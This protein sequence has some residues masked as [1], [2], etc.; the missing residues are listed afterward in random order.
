M[1]DSTLFIKLIQ[2]MCVVATIA[3]VLT[4]ID[5]FKRIFQDNLSSKD[6]CFLI[7]IFGIMGIIGTYTG[8]WLDEG[9]LANSRVIGVMVGGLLGG[10][11]VGAGAGLIAGLHRLSLGGLTAEAC[12]VATILEGLLGGFLAKKWRR[13]KMSWFIGLR[14]GVLAE[15]LQMSLIL[16]LVRPFEVGYGVVSV[17]GI[18]MITTNSL[19]I[20]IF[21]AILQNVFKERDLV[22]ADLARQSL[23][24][25][26]ETLPYL[27]KGLTEET[28]EKVAGIIYRHTSFDAVA[29]TKNNKLL[30]YVGVGCDHHQ[31]EGSYPLQISDEQILLNHNS[32]IIFV[33]EHFSCPHPSCKLKSGIIIPLHVQGERIGSLRLFLASNYPIGL[34]HLEFANGLAQLFSSQLELALIEH[35]NTLRQKAELRALQTQIQPHFL[36]NSLNTIVSYC[37]TN[38][39]QARELL[40]HLSTIF[41]Q[42]IEQGEYIRIEQEHQYIQAYLAIQKGRF[43]NRI[44]FTANID[45]MLLHHRIPALV[46]QPIVENAVKHGLLAKKE[47]GTISLNIE[48]RDQSIYVSIQDDGEGFSEK[49]EKTFLQRPYE[50]AEGCGIG[51]YNINERLKAIYGEQALLQIYSSEQGTMVSFLLPLNRAVEVNAG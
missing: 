34:T 26:E 35:L 32:S 30:S 39:E 5:L 24:I 42:N 36:F 4:R 14:Y 25:A 7:I 49:N 27:R 38:P 3:F 40:I 47:G 11:V 15:T 48:R 28:A 6:K 21:L 43:G 18:P 10:P 17:I 20:A 45:P 51:L 12:A 41:R 44:N 2:G 23:Q 16:L 50:S 22:A 46:I 31:D 33:K 9:V 37:R 1:L 8:Y 29:V 19:G 13:E